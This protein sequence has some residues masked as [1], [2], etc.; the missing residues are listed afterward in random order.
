LDCVIQI[1]N[2]H[3]CQFNKAIGQQFKVSSS[4]KKKIKKKEKKN[5][6]QKTMLKNFIIF[7]VYFTVVYIFNQIS[8]STYL[9]F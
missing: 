1:P 9:P 7:S 5:L 2:N 6:K 3:F 4:S 8:Y